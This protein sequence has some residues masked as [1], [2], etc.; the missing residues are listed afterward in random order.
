MIRAEAIWEVFPAGSYASFGLMRLLDIR[1][2]REVETAALVGADMPVILIHPDF[3]SRYARTPERQAALILHELLHLLLGHQLRPATRLDNFIFDALI[4]AMIC[5]MT[6]EPAY[7]SLFTSYYSSRRFPECLL[8]PPVGFSLKNP[9]FVAVPVPRVLRGR[10]M[11]KARQVYQELYDDRGT[12]YSDVRRL[13]QIQVRFHKDLVAGVDIGAV[14]RMVREEGTEGLRQREW[15]R[16]A[17]EDAA[18]AWEEPEEL[19]DH[20]PSLKEVRLLGSHPACRNDGEVP[21]E[22]VQAVAVAL[23]PIRERL[24]RRS[25]EEAAYL[26]D[27]VIGA[28]LESRNAAALARLIERVALA[29]HAQAR[30]ERE[31][32]RQLMTALPALDRR[33]N[34]LRFL[35][36][37]PLLYRWEMPE[38]QR[39]QITP[40]H[41]YLDVSGSATPFIASLCR[42]VLSCRDLVFPRVHLFS[43]RIDTVP[44]RSL[45]SGSLRSWCGTD[46]RCVLQHMKSQNIR[47]AVI[48]TDGYVGRPDSSWEAF[49]RECTIAVAL[50]PGGSLS[51]LKAW[52]RYHCRLV[53]D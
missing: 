19:P 3:A 18:C 8:R 51:D 26:L 5:Y 24:P 7:W 11:W 17:Q 39:Q 36:L 27:P 21:E 10:R 53:R 50:T 33:S 6:R 38:R 35:G 25:R 31:D 40:V 22:I 52:V 43:T 49:L 41:V 1:E 14:D 45:T 13:F 37:E 47:R 16:W 28:E 20:I 12:T 32:T 29:G 46:I 44:V 15:V 48:L 9:E 4:N 34:V 2:S 42:A 30:S 23:A